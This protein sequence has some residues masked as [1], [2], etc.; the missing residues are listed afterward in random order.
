MGQYTYTYDTHTST[1]T[2]IIA[3]LPLYIYYP[4][5]KHS[6]IHVH[7]FPSQSQTATTTT[8]LDASQKQRRASVPPP[9]FYTQYFVVR[10]SFIYM[11]IYIVVVV[12]MTP[13]LKSLRK[14]QILVVVVGNRGHVHKRGCVCLCVSSHMGHGNHLFVR[15]SSTWMRLL[16]FL[17]NILSV[18]LRHVRYL[19]CI[20]HNLFCN[21]CIYDY[22]RFM[23][24]R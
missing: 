16:L 14:V 2:L 22:N 5:C 7:T 9:T 23:L 1:R 18:L 21:I 3:P 19:K 20:S 13:L 10:E 12:S 6:H 4:L 15:F 11:Y 24:Y 17:I 8:T